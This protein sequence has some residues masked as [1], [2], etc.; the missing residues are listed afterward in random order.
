M[1][2]TISA[3]N[4]TLFLVIASVLLFSTVLLI[5]VYFNQKEKL[6]NLEGEYH[7]NIKSTYEKILEQHQ[8]FYKFRLLNVI[9]IK[10]VR[11][12]FYNQDREALY[13]LVT[14]H[15]E[16]F[17]EENSYLKIMHFHLPNG[18]SFLR[19]H[20]KEKF[21]DNIAQKR[22]MAKAMHEHKKPLNG[23]ESGIYMLAY[24][25][26]MPLFYQEN[27][28]GSLEIGSRPDQILAQMDYLFD[29]KGALFVKE[30]KIIEYAEKSNLKIGDYRL[31]YNTLQS[32][33]L[34]QIIPKEYDFSSKIEVYFQ[35]KTYVLYPFD[36]FDYEGKVSAKALYFHDITQMKNIFKET[37]QKL[38]F[39]LLGLMAV[40]I[41]VIH[42]GFSKIIQ[43]IQSI[44]DKL[45]KSVYELE[46]NKL[47]MDSIV[48]NSAH[49]I[50]ATDK[51]GV[52]T[53][54]NKKAES[55]L[56][57]ASDEVVAK[58]TPDIFHQKEE[59][60]RKEKEFQK[61]FGIT[62]KKP[63][64]VLVAKTD[65]GL[66]NDDEWIVVNKA[67]QELVVALHITSLLDLEG[68]VRGYLGIMQDLSASKIKE[69]QIAQYIALINKNIITSTTD[70]QGNIT[71]A[72]EAFC[73]ISEYTKEELIGQ[74][75]R[76]VRHPETPKEIFETMWEK[77]VNGGFW[78]GE[79]KNKTKSGGFYWVENKIYPIYDAKTNKKIGYTA[80]RQDITDKKIIE[81]ISITDGLTHIYNRRHFNELFPKIINGA[82]RDNSLTCFLLMDIDHF[83]QYNDN[84]GHQEG[85]NVLVAFA[86]CLKE[87]FKRA[88]DTV[89]R[90][91]GEEFGVIYKADDT[92][93]ALEF[94][95]RVKENIEA[96][97]I[98]HAHN[99]A[100]PY[101]TASMGLVCKNALSIKD[102]DE[103]YKEADD[104]LYISKKSGRNRV[105]S[106][107]N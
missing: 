71:Y 79:I 43:T 46:N 94:A 98:P 54:F 41:F 1:F 53:L 18:D 64:E 74:N 59:L 103:I 48:Q 89:F 6:Q 73:K 52:I 49:G 87:T 21:G 51:N 25:E 68:T 37:V 26:F 14:P 32:E 63:F 27:Y 90:L 58:H 11:E 36:I 95:H 81:E 30:N 93:K 20:E 47:F 78:E 42:K 33:A 88:G 10:G 56:L 57:Y 67:N 17:K 106:N 80:I 55:M 7:E 31:Q 104:L 92:T 22:A 2:Q 9:N 5:F 12:A 102:M 15:F 70:L 28:I 4:K 69:K 99:S 77:I 72:S 76:I 60:L 34:L 50:I 35:D 62:L 66:Q 85:D 61:L 44:N 100:S 23:F 105:S 86:T 65:L 29:L 83:K 84:Y 82:K 16:M 97:K 45:V 75:H 40:L 13:T 96:M 38:L 8:N 91:G 107:Q 101:I 39:L 24:R 19:L 3:K